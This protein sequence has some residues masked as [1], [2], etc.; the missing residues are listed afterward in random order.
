[1]PSNNI[2][3]IIDE[4]TVRYIANLSRISIDEK[5]M[6]VFIS[7]LE[8]ILEYVNQ[9]NEVDTKNCEPTTHVL[10]SMSN[11]FRSD[12]LKESISSEK[13]VGNAPHK[14]GKFFRVPRII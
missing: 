2:N 5:N 12:T 7:N 13:A 8:S 6:P 3:K 4:K 11:V 14:D 1:M 10:P 9:L